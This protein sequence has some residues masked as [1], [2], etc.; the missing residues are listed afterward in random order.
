MMSTIFVT[1]G[2]TAAATALYDETWHLAWGNGDEAWD[3]TPVAEPIAATALVSEVGRKVCTQIA[4][5]T[6]D[7]EGEIELS[8]TDK[9]SIV[10]SPTRYLYLRF[11]FSPTDGVSEVLR[12]RGLFMG[13]E[14]VGGLPEGQTYFEPSD[15]S[16]PGQLVL[17]TRFNRFT[18]SVDVQER[19]EYVLEL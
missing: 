1:A 3:T 7:D 13:T 15:I 6:P 4:Y 17:L 8:E 9:F 14:V 10:E 16:D 2:R 19:F 12:E 18:R 11:Q 5:C